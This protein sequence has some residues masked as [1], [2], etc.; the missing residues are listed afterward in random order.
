MKVSKSQSTMLILKYLLEDKRVSREEI[1]DQ[2]DIS[3][4]TFRRYIQEI[5]AFLANFYFNY[6]VVYCKKD[7]CYY[8]ETED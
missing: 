3:E 1:L 6:E 8:L 7:D 5:R 4:L 2:V